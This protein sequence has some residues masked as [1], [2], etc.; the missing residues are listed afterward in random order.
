ML[1]DAETKLI[2]ESGEEITKWEY[3]ELNIERKRA[4]SRLTE[5]LNIEIEKNKNKHAGFTTE[6]QGRIEDTIFSIEKITTAT[7]NEFKKVKE[8]IH[9]LGK[10]DYTLYRQTIYRQ[11]Y[12]EA[13]KGVKEFKNYQVLKDKLDSFV[14][15]KDFYEYIQKSDTLSD[16]FL[17]Y[18][19]GDGL[20]YGSF[21]TNEEAFDSA[22]LELGLIKE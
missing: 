9:R 4:V 17:Y 20:V 18:K 10:T 12:Y 3:K 21:A 13:L 16:L 5:E 14:S 11:N 2:L 22:L 6:K 19:S 7:G 1:K 15:P 8:R